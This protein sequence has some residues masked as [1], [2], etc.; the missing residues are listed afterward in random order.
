MGGGYLILLGISCAG[1]LEPNTMNKENVW[2]IWGVTQLLIV[3]ILLVI[4]GLIAK[5]QRR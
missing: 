4:L 5:D 2:R 3:G 1:M